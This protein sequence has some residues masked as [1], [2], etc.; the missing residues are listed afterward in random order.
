M[1]TLSTVEECERIFGRLRIR[2]ERKV[3]RAI[4]LVNERIDFGRIYEKLG[5]KLG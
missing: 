4:D 2:D 1:D 5:L 3:R